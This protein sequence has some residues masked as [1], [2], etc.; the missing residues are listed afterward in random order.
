MLRYRLFVLM[1]G[2]LV[3]IG[4][5]SIAQAETKPNLPKYRGTLE[6]AVQ[7]AIRD[8]ATIPT[9]ATLFVNRIS[10]YEQWSFGSVSVF[11]ESDAAPDI[12]LFLAKQQS[13]TWAVAI[14]HTTHFATALRTIPR[15][16]L[17]PEQWATLTSDQPITLAADEAVTLQD[18]RGLAM[19]LPWPVGESRYLTQGPHAPGGSILAALDFAGSPGAL[20]HAARGGVVYHACPGAAD[21]Y[22]RIDHGGGVES[23]YY[24]LDS[25][26]VPNGQWVSR[27]APIGVQGTKVRCGGW[28]TG[29]HF[30]FWIK[31]NG[32]NLAIDGIDIG[33]WRVSGNCMVRIRDGLS[34]CVNSLIVNEGAIGTG[35]T[36]GQP[37]DRVEVFEQAYN[38]NGGAAKVGYPVGP[39]R[40]HGNTN[41]VL[42]QEFDGGE[43]GA[44]FIVLDR[45]SDEQVRGTP[46]YII[47]GGIWH[48]YRHVLGAWDSWLGPPTS[49]EY[50]NTDGKPQQNFRNGIL[51]YHSSENVEARPWPTPV[52]GQWRIEYRNYLSNPSNVQMGPTWVRNGALYPVN[53]LCWGNGSPLDGK[54]GVWADYFTVRMSGRFYFEEGVYRFRARA[55]DVINLYINQNPVILDEDASQVNE[56][57]VVDRYIS[58]GYHNVL[59]EFTELTGHACLEFS[60]TKLP[61]PEPPSN[62]RQIGRTITSITLTWQDNSTDETGFYIYVQ[63]G[64]T[65]NRIATLGANATTHTITDLQCGQS[66]TYRVSAYS[67]DGESA[68]SNTV[69]ATTADC[70][71]FLFMLYL[72]GDND[73]YRYIA[74]ALQSLERATA[75]PNVKIVVLVDG[76]QNGDTQR[77]VFEATSI[78]RELLGELNMG[79]PQ[80][81]QEFVRWARDTYPARYSYLALAG[82]G[83]GL[84]GIGP[85]QNSGNDVL[86]PWEIS[87]A[88]RAAT[89]N[90]QRKID[91]V[92]YDAC[93][94]ALLEHAYELRNYAGYLI[95]SQYLAWSVFAYQ[96]YAEQVTLQGVPMLESLN[97]AIAE[98]SA[99]STPRSLATQIAERY[100]GHAAL[101]GSPRTISVLDLGH[102][103]SVMQALDQLLTLLQNNLQ[104]VKT[105]LQRARQNVQK[106]DSREPLYKITQEDEYI[107]L[108]HWASLVQSIP[109]SS[110]NAAAQQVL[111][112]VRNQ[113]VVVSRR[114]SG[115][116]DNLSI[117]LDNANGVSIYFPLSS[118]G[119]AFQSYSSHRL[120]QFTANSQWDD[121]LNHYFTVTTLPIIDLGPAGLLP[122]L[123]PKDIVY[124]PLVVR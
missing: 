44:L 86:E 40:W 29:A 92:H 113:L 101:I 91:I 122:L 103:E 15:L 65:W 64:N 85:D 58:A 50:I 5:L 66:Y 34:R 67:N 59:A 39:V 105:D 107:D 95:A 89:N 17:T 114:E 47:R 115:N 83:N 21:T 55:D 120:F 41:R 123:R 119:N 8:Q 61:V 6:Q 54:W 45:P 82:H 12:V 88:L 104:S 16:L 75:N 36:I 52:D 37:S 80:T 96:N 20:V 10:E 56:E 111:D 53:S 94:M 19:G 38:R 100:F 81:L 70:T 124:V 97:E 109:N 118:G 26:S 60:W 9:N 2:I 87:Q 18:D 43:L 63:N 72:N 106:F 3:I 74:R 77:L 102:V 7:T 117:N 14:E 110:I 11:P 31:V 30:Q 68:P 23:H 28:V 90:G 13:D 35:Y 27:W 4:S 108:V 48:H 49:D 71:L 76:D 1:T 46:A 33:G 78:Q 121:F 84:L 24:H 57:Y 79:N 93:S 99:A 62:L 98:V 51:I 22:V 112:R 116:I 42:L 73:L 32:Q 25:I 69:T